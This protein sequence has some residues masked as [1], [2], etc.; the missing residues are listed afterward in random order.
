MEVSIVQKTTDWAEG[1]GCKV[2]DKCF[3]ELDNAI[4]YVNS[5]GGIMGA[6]PRVS[7]RRLY[8]CGW[9]IALVEVDPGDDSVILLP[10]KIKK[11]VWVFK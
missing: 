6:T 9:E 8:D 4:D 3:L 2:I 10:H 11:S 7:R 5:Q 1:R